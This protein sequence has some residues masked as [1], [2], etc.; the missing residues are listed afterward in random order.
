MELVHS[1]SHHYDLCSERIEQISSNNPAKPA[2][3]F[4]LFRDSIPVTPDH[5]HHVTR[6]R[7]VEV[8]AV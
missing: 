4:R 1:L 3:I 2:H 7:A 5:I 6:V 8:R